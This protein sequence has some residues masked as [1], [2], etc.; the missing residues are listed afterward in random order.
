MGMEE[1]TV[2][3]LITQAH[4]PMHEGMVISVKM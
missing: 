1:L 2:N 4:S 3:E